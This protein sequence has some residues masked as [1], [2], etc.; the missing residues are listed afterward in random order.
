MTYDLSFDNDSDIVKAG[1]NKIVYL[2][3]TYQNEVPEDK[4]VNT[5]QE[6]KEFNLELLNED[7]TA[8]KIENPKTGITSVI[9][10][11]VVMISGVVAFVVLRKYRKSKMLVLILLVSVLPLATYALETLTIDINS[12]VVIE[13]AKEFCYYDYH[14]IERVLTNTST[15]KE[16]DLPEETLD[17]SGSEPRIRPKVYIKYRNGMTWEEFLNSKYSEVTDN[18][19]IRYKNQNINVKEYNDKVNDYFNE[20]LKF[21][22]ILS[23]SYHVDYYNYLYYWPNI[24]ENYNGDGIRTFAD[25]N[26][27]KTEFLQSKIIDSSEGCYD[28][29]CIN[30][31]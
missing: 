15:G 7:G 3:I 1:A 14:D 20:N 8:A 28:Y 21:E 2:T 9:P 26:Y 4:L 17:I 12:K 31:K 19:T 29:I 30:C 5:Y 16:T 13:N 6:S 25:D 24:F 23:T 11:F 10:M 22:N 27:S 18:T